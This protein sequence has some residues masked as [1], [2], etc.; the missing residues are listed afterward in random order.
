MQLFSFS[1]E[2]DVFSQ[3]DTVSQIDRRVLHY[4]AL[5]I[6]TTDCNF[7]FGRFMLPLCKLMTMAFFTACFFAIVRLHDYMNL[8]SLIILSLLAWCSFF[9]LIPATIIM[10]NL[11]KISKNFKPCLIPCIKN[12]N[13]PSKQK[14]LLER[15]LI[16][17]GIIRCEVGGF[18]YMESKAKLTVVHK[19][20]NILKYLLVNVK[21][22]EGSEYLQKWTNYILYRRRHN[23][24]NACWLWERL[25]LI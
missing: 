11:Y 18:Y 17:C 1:T 21:V 19:L 10:S 12:L 22:W 23:L 9:L 14:N 8:L 4:K 15:Q 25:T 3:E 6:I 2:A 20:V 7:V 13:V 24:L 16:S 5:Y